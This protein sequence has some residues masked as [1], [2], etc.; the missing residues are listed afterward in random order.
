MTTIDGRTARAIRTRDLIVDACIGLVDEGDLRPTAP[1]VAERA[2]VSV[3]SVFQHF[4]DLEGLYAA[5]GD[6]VAD[7]LQSLVLVIHPAEPLAVRL[8]EVV[9]QRS[10]LLE[11]ITPILR[12][13]AVHAWGSVEVDNRVR[14]GRRFLHDEVAR[15]FSPEIDARGSDGPLLLDA[16]DAALSWPLWEHLRTTGQHDVEGASAVVTH[17]VA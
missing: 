7:R 2:G 5:V 1:K 6:R 17:I 13:T 3:R 14:F 10:D 4:A 9:R 12:A 8:P 15:A 16:L 11:A